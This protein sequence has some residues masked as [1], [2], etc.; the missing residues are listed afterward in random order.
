MHRA[1]PTLALGLALCF[2]LAGCDSG[3]GG[4]AP[5]ID[6]QSEAAFEKSLQKVRST[7][8]PDEA[9]QLDAVIT[10]KRWKGQ[11]TKLDGLTGAQ[12]LAQAAAETAAE[13]EKM[14]KYQQLTWQMERLSDLKLSEEEYKARRQALLQ[15]IKALGIRIPDSAF[16]K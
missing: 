16:D 3:A 2:L 14:D 15:E 13:K 9:E 11:H 12:I 1:S 7:L 10:A 8:T 5:T 4:S 6:G